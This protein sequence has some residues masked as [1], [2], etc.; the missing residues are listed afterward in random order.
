MRTLS[1]LA[2]VCAV[3]FAGCGR[4]DEAGGGPAGAAAPTATPYSTEVHGLEG[5][6]RVRVSDSV[7][8]RLDAGGVG[9]VDFD[10]RASIAPGTLWLN[11]QQKLVDVRWSGWGGEQVTGTARVRSVVCDPNC[12]R[13]RIEMLDGKIELSDVRLCGSRRYYSKA[14]LETT[15]PTTGE[16]GRPA[17]FLRTPC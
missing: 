15:D 4:E 13:G 17:A 8:R 2:V 11:E 6:P 12:A 3:I 16:R 7:A 1:L 5:R 14:R 9:I 10:A